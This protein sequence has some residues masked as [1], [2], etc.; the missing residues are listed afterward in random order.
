MRDMLAP[1]EREITV[2]A[3]AETT[4]YVDQS[5]LLW[6]AMHHVIRRY[7]TLHPDLAIR[8]SRRFVA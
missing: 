6:R 2:L 7:Q 4:D 1:F 3:K 5:I 8:P